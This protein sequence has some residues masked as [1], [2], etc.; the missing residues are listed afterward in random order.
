MGQVALGAGNAREYETI[1]I[2]RPTIDK[3]VADSLITT[4]RIL[5]H[6]FTDD[7]FQFRRKRCIG[8]CRTT[9]PRPALRIGVSGP[10]PASCPVGME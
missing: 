2:L 10:A 8:K 4:V 6:A 5:F 9:H 1:Y 7:P 3:E